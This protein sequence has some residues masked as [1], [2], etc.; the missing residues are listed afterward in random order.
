MCIELS[1]SLTA[2]EKSQIENLFTDCARKDP[3]T[4]SPLIPCEEEELTVLFNRENGRLLSILETAPV[5]PDIWELRAFTHPEHR[6]K[7]CLRRLFTHLSSRLF[8]DGLPEFF[9][10]DDG[11]SPDT[12][13]LIRHLACP[14]WDTEHLLALEI[15]RKAPKRPDRAPVISAV[16][17]PSPAALT[18]IHREVFDWPASES[19]EYLAA[20]GNDPDCRAFLLRKDGRPV[21]CFLLTTDRESACLSGFGLTP[22]CRSRGLSSPALQTVLDALP[23]SCRRLNVQVSESNRPAYRL[24]RKAGFISVSRLSSYRFTGFS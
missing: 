12:T 5:S 11:S 8:P 22:D 10:Y 4:L 24:Y 1:F 16:P 2:S 7:G 14:L 6:R 23:A 17:C 18:Q 9:F 3:L 15:P 21:G 13:A 20:C 19:E